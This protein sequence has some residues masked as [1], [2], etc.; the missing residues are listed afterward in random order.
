MMYLIVT[1]LKV[2]RFL[3]VFINHNPFYQTMK[4]R[5]R[6]GEIILKL[7]TWK[8]TQNDIEPDTSKIL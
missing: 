5:F 3:L 7:I 1:P 2:E 6:A 4:L 8:S